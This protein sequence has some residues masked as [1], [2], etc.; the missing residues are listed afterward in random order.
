MLFLSQDLIM[1]KTLLSLY[2]KI[3]FLILYLYLLPKLHGKLNNKLD[4][5]SLKLIGWSYIKFDNQSSNN[6]VS[7]G[8]NVFA[9]NLTI[10]FRGNNNSLIIEDNVSWGGHIVI[11]GNN[12]IIKIG[13][14]STAKSAYILSRDCNVYIGEDCM[15]SRS[16]EIRSTDVHKVFDLETNKRLNMPDDVYI[17]NHV[18]IAAKVTISKGSCIADGCVVGANSFVN[19]KFEEKNIVIAGIPAKVVREGIRWAR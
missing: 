6:I 17:G 11:H 9:N 4:I 19:K 5:G 10:I 14:K 3:K 16:I 12:R 18:W 8:N 2:L 15:L 7:I 1:F 13:Q